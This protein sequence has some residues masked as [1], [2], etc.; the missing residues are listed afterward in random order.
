[1][2][3][4][5]LYDIPCAANKGPVV[6]VLAGQGASINPRA[7]LVDW[8]RIQWTGE[9]RGTIC[10][11]RWWVTIEGL[12]RLVQE[13]APERQRKQRDNDLRELEGSPLGHRGIA[14]VSAGDEVSDT[15]MKPADALVQMGYEIDR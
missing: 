10:G 15:C 9:H 12:E 6:S 2:K 4:D 3:V 13:P 8:L 7:H 11:N 5:G 14:V 1:M